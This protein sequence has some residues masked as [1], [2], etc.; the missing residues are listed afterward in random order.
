MGQQCP[1]RFKAVI[2]MIC[3]QQCIDDAFQLCATTSWFNHTTSTT[4]CF[5]HKINTNDILKF[6]K[7]AHLMVFNEADADEGFLEQPGGSTAQHQQQCIFWTSSTRTTSST[8]TRWP[9]SWTS[10]SRRARNWRLQ[11]RKRYIDVSRSTWRPGVGEWENVENFNDVAPLQKKLWRMVRRTDKACQRRNNVTKHVM[12]WKRYRWLQ[13]WWYNTFVEQQGGW[14]M[15][16]QQQYIFTA[17]K[18]KMEYIQNINKQQGGWTMQLQQQYIYIRRTR[19]RWTTPRRS[20]S[21]SISRRSKL[22][23][24]VG[25]WE[26]V[27][28]FNDIANLERKKPGRTVRP[29]DKACQWR[30]HMTK[31]DKAYTVMNWKQYRWLQKWW[32]YTFVEQQGGWTMQPQQQ[33]I[34]TANK[35]KMDYI[36]K[37]NKQQ[38]GWTMQLQ[39]QYL[40]IYIRRT[41]SRWTTPRRS[42]SRSISRRSTLRPGD[43]E[44]EYVGNFNDVAVDFQKANM[45]A[46]RWRL[47]KCW[48]FQWRS[49]AWGKKPGRT[50]RRTDKTCQRCNNVTKHDKAHIVMNWKQYH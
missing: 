24:G 48:K 15:Q 46:W 47:R 50:V 18:A 38:G 12:N 19:S 43:G 42:T 39:Q 22:R 5:L 44:W 30:N 17:N 25:E 21:R 27:G 29:T 41:R 14:T 16:P 3:N 36:Q 10:T 26:Y 37:I 6:N 35:V 23:P 33:Y 4:I 20:T 1:K 13:K 11:R 2:V 32:C 7:M 31:H 49:E 34:F 28:N 45:A 40:Y 8:S 9:I